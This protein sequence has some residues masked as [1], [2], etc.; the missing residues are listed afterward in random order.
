[1][2]ITKLW[3]LIDDWRLWAVCGIAFGL[4]ALGGVI[5]A[6]TAEPPP[7]PPPP[8]R[9][10]RWAAARLFFVGGIAAVAVMYVTLPESAM[11]LI[12]GSLVAGYAGK[13]ILDALESRAKL[14]AATARA[15]ENRRLALRAFDTIPRGR[16]LVVPSHDKLALIA[17]AP[18]TAA[19]AASIPI[20]SAVKVVPYTPP[21]EPIIEVVPT[22]G[23]GQLGAW[24]VL[25]DGVL[26]ASGT[27]PRP[28]ALGKGA[29]LA[30]K[31]LEVS[32]AISD[33]HGPGNNR[34]SLRVTLTGRPDPID[35]EHEV[36]DG[37]RAAYS[38]IVP[39]GAA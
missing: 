18:D 12:G 38:I 15:D 37:G 27:E 21:A 22:I 17:A 16:E 32:A 4:G 29:S 2:D 26:K 35:L 13:A 1:M 11:A 24:T 5:R 25:L 9:D 8:R 6:L 30:G 7:D 33:A 39:F 28:V 34:L 19:A 20:K 3:G 31:R 14:A 36:P 23:N 10:P